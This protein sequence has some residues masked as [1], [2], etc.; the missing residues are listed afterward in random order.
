M[1][2]Y[3]I[4]AQESRMVKIGY[5]VDPIARLAELQTGNHDVLAII[6]VV[7]GAQFTEGCFHHFFAQNRV[8][9]EWFIFDERM[10]TLEPDDVEIPA[11]LVREMRDRAGENQVRFAARLGVHQ[12]V[13]S[14]WEKRG[15]PSRGV[16]RKAIELLS[17]Q[18]GKI[19]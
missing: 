13:I 4:Q 19:G 8:R 5:A 1:P 16:A 7:S 6:R 10:L 11:N 14:R 17:V 3:F 18:L 2:V 9:G 15:I 12:S